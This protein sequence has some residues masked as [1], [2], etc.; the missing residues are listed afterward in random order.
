MYYRIQG[1]LK[2]KKYGNNYEQRMN[3]KDK[4]VGEY[5]QHSLNVFLCLK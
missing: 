5:R 1:S 4:H 3:N 2:V